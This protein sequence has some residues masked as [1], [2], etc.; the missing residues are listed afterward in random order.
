[1]NARTNL[2][3]F[4]ALAMACGLAISAV[5]EAT[6][7]SAKNNDDRRTVTSS[8][9]THGPEDRA[10]DNDPL[11]WENRGQP[12]FGGV[13]VTAKA[14]K[15]VVIGAGFVQDATARTQWF[16]RAVDSATGSTM[17]EDRYGPFARG[18]PG[19]RAFDLKIEGRTAFISGWTGGLTNPDGFGFVVRAIDAI[20]GV[21]QWNQEVRVGSECGEERPGFGRCVAKAIDVEDGR[22]FAVGHMTASAGHQSDFAVVALD[23]DTGDRLWIDRD[24]GSGFDA[25]WAVVAEEDL[26]FVLGESDLFG[27]TDGFRGV[28][29]RAYDARTGD[30]QWERQFSAAKIYTLNSTLAAGHNRVFVATDEQAPG[31]FMVRALDAASGATVWT[32]RIDDAT[33]LGRAEALAFEKESG[34]GKLIASGVTGCN[35]DSFE[36]ELV[37]RMYDPKSGLIWQRTD[38]ARGG[39]WAF[40][41][42]VMAGKTGFFFAGGELLEDGQYHYL[43]RSFAP[44]T[45]V[46]LSEDAF[47][48]G[49][50]VPGFI[51]TIDGF[52]DQLLIGGVLFRNSG[53]GFD[54]VLRAYDA[55]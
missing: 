5:P 44:R 21:V 4:F 55:P 26:V 18:G 54:F 46:I 38:S 40:P 48:A 50:D 49:A 20:D 41:A 2:T 45:G 43:I 15:E 53:P 13:V 51:T 32:D 6:R 12:E 47:D 37:L 11:V 9:P 25:A 36:C 34:S 52:K 23:A 10:N 7:V 42:R 3:K 35:A 39:D 19:S 28:W 30:V 29:L 24:G 33:S 27:T 8:L 16:V 22:V 31:D 1:M 14:S 17:W